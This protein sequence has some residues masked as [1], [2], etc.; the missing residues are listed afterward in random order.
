[1]NNSP[2]YWV[3]IV[4]ASVVMMFLGITQGYSG[5]IEAVQYIC[6]FTIV[7][8]ILDYFSSEEDKKQFVAVPQGGSLRD[9]MMYLIPGY[10]LVGLIL[11]ILI[12]IIQSIM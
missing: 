11:V 10:A 8:I 6:V 3:I 5:W 4:S 1:M 12:A 9:N 7:G 2:G